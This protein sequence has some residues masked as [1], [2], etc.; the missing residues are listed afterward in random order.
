MI[1]Q[2]LK[3]LVWDIRKIFDILKI[4]LVECFSQII[5][6]LYY[7]VPECRKYL[8]M[9]KLWFK[10]SNFTENLMQQYTIQEEYV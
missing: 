1:N 10:S 6:K 5:N 3:L 7:A 2:Y 8:R 9:P 4:A